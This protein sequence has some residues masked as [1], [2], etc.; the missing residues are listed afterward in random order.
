M[1]CKSRTFL[2]FA[3]K[4]VQRVRGEHRQ[5][6]IYKVNLGELYSLSITKGTVN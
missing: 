1:N 2:T 4:K 5:H 3:V 6:Y